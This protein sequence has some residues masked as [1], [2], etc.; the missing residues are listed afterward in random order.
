MGEVQLL[1]NMLTIPSYS[2]QEGALAGYLV[3]QARQMGLHACIDDAGNFIASTHAPD[4]DGMRR[5]RRL[6][7]LVIWI[8]YVVTFR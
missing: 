5:C 7:C 4:G 3:E 1:Y 6:F 8:R 2:G